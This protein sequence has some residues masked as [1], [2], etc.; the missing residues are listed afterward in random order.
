[1]NREQLENAMLFKSRTPNRIERRKELGITSR[2]LGK[3]NKRR[4]EHSDE[5][6]ISG[7]LVESKIIVNCNGISR[8]IN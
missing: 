2:D 4:E 1:M 5:V 6:N 7:N 8:R 3:R